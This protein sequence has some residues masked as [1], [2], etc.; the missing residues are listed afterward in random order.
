MHIIYYVHLVD[1][2]RSDW[3]QV[4]TVWRASK[5]FRLYLSWSCS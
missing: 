1:I 5:L 3:L 4:L 2:K